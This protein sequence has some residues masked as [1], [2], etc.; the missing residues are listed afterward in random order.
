MSRPSWGESLAGLFVVETLLL[1]PDLFRGYIALSPSVWWNGGAAVRLAGA[2]R[3]AAP[4]RVVYLAAANES[5]I[6]EGTARLAAIL[7]AD[8]AARMV[9]FD[10]PVRTSR[11]TPYSGRWLPKHSSRSWGKVHSAMTD[12]RYSDNEIAAIFKQASETSPQALRG[13]GRT[14]GLTLAELKEIGREVGIAP[15][16]VALA[17]RSMDAG[18]PARTTKFLGL[19]LSVERTV[20]LDRPMMDAQWERLVVQLREVFNAR[21]KASSTVRSGMDQWG[22]LQV[23]L[24]PV[25]GGARLGSDANGAARRDCHRPRDG[26]CRRGRWPLHSG[27]RAAG[28]ITARRG[29]VCGDGRGRCW[30]MARSGCPAVGKPRG[31]S[32]WMRS[33]PTWYSRPIPRLTSPAEASA[34][35]GRA[36]RILPGT[37]SCTDRWCSSRRYSARTAPTD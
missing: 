6:A 18:L 14:E 26:R 30:R 24:E 10:V 12:R 34:A 15:E 2:G 36:T 28:Y 31:G 16:A 7:R 1:E 21:G 5:Q 4:Y 37:G 3:V 32:R 20:E 25:Q 22:N 23:L 9:L 8:A 35:S 29:H 11:T 19:P 13:A 17:A 33:R 27:R